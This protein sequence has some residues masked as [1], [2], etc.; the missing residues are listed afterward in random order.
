M[1]EGVRPL[2]AVA[3]EYRQVR[4]VLI[5]YSASKSSANAMKQFVQAALWPTAELHIGAFTTDQQRAR[6][7]LDEAIGY[8][9][10]HDREATAIHVAT[11]A[12]KGVL[13][14]ATEHEIDLMVMGR[15]HAARASRLSANRPGPSDGDHSSRRENSPGAPRATPRLQPAPSGRNRFPTDHDSG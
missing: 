14:Y 12:R 15:A 11:G 4:R 3:P 13:D 9:Q 7:R 1:R 10:A 2:I 8:C 6:A 5:A